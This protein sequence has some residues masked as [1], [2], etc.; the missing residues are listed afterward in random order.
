MASVTRFFLLIALLALVDARIHQPLRKSVSGGS[1]DLQRQSATTKAKEGYATKAI[2]CAKCKKAG[3]Q[4]C[5]AASCRPNPGQPPCDFTQGTYNDD[6]L[7]FCDMNPT[8]NLPPAY[9]AGQPHPE[10]Y[11]G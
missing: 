7:W 6:F 3:C 1:K 11:C 5:W 8:D 10:D 9:G 2:A 4:H